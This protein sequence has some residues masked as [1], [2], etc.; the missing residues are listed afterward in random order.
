MV[1]GDIAISKRRSRWR[2]R[3]EGKAFLAGGTSKLGT[4][5]WPYPAVKFLRGWIDEPA[6]LAAA[7]EDD[8]RTEAR[9]VLGLDHALK[10]HTDAAREHFRWVRDHGN[11]SVVEFL[12]ALAELERLAP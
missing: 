5:T 4:S 1:A 10:G 6:L 11:P 2:I 9:C 3:R 8:Q 12:I 7:T